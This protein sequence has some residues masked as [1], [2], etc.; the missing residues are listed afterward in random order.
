[1][2]HILISIVFILAA[3]ASA[4]AQYL[5]EQNQD[6]TT[7]KEYKQAKATTATGAAI[8]GAG[9]LTNLVG[10]VI[11]VIEMNKYTNAHMTTGT[12]DEVLALN[13]EAKQLPGYKTGQ[14]CEIAGF[15]ATVAGLGIVLYGASKTKKI[16]NAAG[17]TVATL[18]YDASPA[19]ISLAL[20]F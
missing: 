6:Y 3:A 5:P 2:K 8:A 15:A 19:G 9:L 16:K 11:C 18:Q 17:A 1:M 14:I 13:Q 12:I 7:S 4:Y 10:N 20:N